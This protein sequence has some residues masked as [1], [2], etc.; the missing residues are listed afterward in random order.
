MNWQFDYSQ[1]SFFFILMNVSWY[2]TVSVYMIE[3]VINSLNTEKLKEEKEK[4]KI[5]SV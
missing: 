4:E 2:K 1:Y 3:R 5:R